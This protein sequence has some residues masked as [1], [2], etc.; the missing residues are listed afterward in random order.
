MKP[1]APNPAL[2]VALAVL[3][4]LPALYL[5]HSVRKYFG[6]RRAYGIDH[7][8]ESYRAL[9]FVKQGIFKYTGNAMYVAGFLI[10][11]TP[12]LLLLSTAAL[13]AALFNHLYIWVHYYCTELPDI[14]RIYGAGPE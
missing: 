7:F 13:L 2:A 11:W 12:G 6:F 10:L 3:L 9:P 4:L 1:R 8:D 14:R 5:F